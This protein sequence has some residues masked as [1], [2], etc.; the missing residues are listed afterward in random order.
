MICQE[1][2]VEFLQTLNDE[3]LECELQRELTDHLQ[4]LVA[5]IE[6]AA[7]E[8]GKSFRSCVIDDF[9]ITRVQFPID[10]CVVLLFYNASA[11]GSRPGP[12]GNRSIFGSALL[13]IDAAGDVSCRGVTFNEEQE[14]VAP[15]VGVA[16]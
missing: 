1:S 14:F 9:A 11:Q 16:D 13:S 4:E 5:G 12:G 10:R 8:R 2:Y 15:D 7:L 6:H 3:E